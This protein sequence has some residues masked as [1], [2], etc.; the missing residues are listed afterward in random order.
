MKVKK[1]LNNIVQEE[2]E[3]IRQKRKEYE[4]D[5]PEVYQIL[6]RGSE[7]AREVAAQTLSEVKSAMKINY[8]DDSELIRIQS[9]KYGQ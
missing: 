4:K 2:L 9:E 5:I 1:F 7:A 8:F 3:P 6:K